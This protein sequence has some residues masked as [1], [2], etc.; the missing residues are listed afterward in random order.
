MS[1]SR[2]LEGVA[3]VVMVSAGRAEDTVNGHLRGRQERRV[4]EWG[5]GHVNLNP[6]ARI[7]SCEER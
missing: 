7:A 6:D 2:F 5:R 1:E 4:G 3:H